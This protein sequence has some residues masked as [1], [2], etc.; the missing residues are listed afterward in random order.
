MNMKTIKVRYNENR[1]KI[2]AEL[3]GEVAELGQVALVI[4]LGTKDSVIK[5][6][7]EEKPN[8][9]IDDIPDARIEK[10][11]NEFKE[12]LDKFYSKI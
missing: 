10:N 2:L 12:L 4:I 9:I 11:V 8:V 1:K 7:G 5:S 3:D 6:L